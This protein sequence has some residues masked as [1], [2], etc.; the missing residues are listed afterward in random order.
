MPA[1]E[2]AYDQ[3]ENSLS[4]SLVAYRIAFCEIT[5]VC[6]TSPSFFEFQLNRRFQKSLCIKAVYHAEFRSS[7]NIWRLFDSI[8]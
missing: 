4:K 5:L 2:K 1:Y 8:H 7:A 3:I 6:C